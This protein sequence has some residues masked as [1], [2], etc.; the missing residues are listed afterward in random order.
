[1]KRY[2]F[3]LVF[4]NS[5][6]NV[7]IFAPRILLRDQNKGA[8][9]SILLAIPLGTLL[10][11]LFSKAMIKFPGKSLPEILKMTLPRWAQ[12]GIMILYG[13]AWLISGV[14]MLFALVTITKRFMNPDLSTNLLLVVFTLL[15]LYVIRMEGLSLLYALE[16]IM[17][18]IV[19]LIIFIYYKA[20]THPLFS[21]N[22]CMEVVTDSFSFPKLTAYG[23]TTYSF[24]GYTD[25]VIFNSVFKDKFQ[26]KHIW[27]FPVVEILLLCFAFFIPIGLLGTGASKIYRY[28]WISTTDSISIQMGPIER[29]LFLF[30]LVYLVISL[31]NV[32]IHWYVSFELL[33]GL[34][35]YQFNVKSLKKVNWII[36][37]SFALIP[38]TYNF[39]S[40]E[41]AILTIG[42][43]W[44]SIRLILEIFLVGILA[45]LAKIAQ[46][47]GLI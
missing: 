37:G 39:I 25:M 40:K 27:L 10:L 9:L 31:A 19:P 41:E 23:V 7:I 24:T 21:W 45:L 12:I 43:I 6:A 35:K 33:K 26:L 38:L 42:G 17:V 20:F 46:K 29:A 4:I 28:P 44:L 32:I 3:Y 15:I 2:F 14:I 13:P 36:I 8:L 18:M 30:L 22:A 47:K 34:F 11:Y 16:I 1:M 5:I